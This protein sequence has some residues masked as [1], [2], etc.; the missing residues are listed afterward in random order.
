[1]GTCKRFGCSTCK[2]HQLV[3]VSVREQVLKP[4]VSGAV[5]APQH[6]LLGPDGSVILSVPY[7]ISADELEWCF[8]TAFASLDKEA[9][10]KRIDKG[11][12]PRRLIMGGVLDLG[13][14]LAPLTRDEAL[15]MIREHKKGASRGGAQAVIRRLVT[16]DEPEVREYV[17]TI[18]RAGGGG[19]GGGGGGR[20][21][22]GG[23]GGRGGGNADKQRIELIQWIGVVSPKAYWEICAEFADSGTEAVQLEAIVALEQLA[24]RESL[25]M[26]T[27]AL[28]RASDEMQEKNIVRA[29]GACG[30]DDK[31]ART[32]VLRASN[33]GKSPTLRANALLALGW[34]D[35]AE[36]VD[37]RIRAGALPGVYGKGAKV[38][39]EE[40][41]GQERLGAVVAMGLTRGERWRELLQELIDDADE[42][43]ALREA[44][45]AS[46]DVVGGAPYSKLGPAVAE[47]GGDQIPRERLFKKARVRRGE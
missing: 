5:V 46:L 2:Q 19:G 45:R 18:L 22:G 11:R 36:E 32:A 37:E 20:G 10:A 42:P 26:L 24:A 12:R 43:E 17:L 27:K 21:G 9:P 23:G 4:D 7:E 6:V 38:D 41:T 28:R 39:A 40:V 33:D 8:L 34:L 13:G 14:G 1:S 16:V 15:E 3:D 35:Q 47:A 31:K 30:Q 44:A 29:I 25:P